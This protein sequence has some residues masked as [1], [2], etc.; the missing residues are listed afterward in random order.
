MTQLLP[1]D[2]VTKPLALFGEAI[3]ERYSNFYNLLGWAALLIMVLW[4]HSLFGFELSGFFR[5]YF[6][7]CCAV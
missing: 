4:P 6:G 3:G 1:S 5:Y 7:Y 2:H